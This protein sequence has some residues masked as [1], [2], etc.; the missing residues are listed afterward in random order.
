M[1]DV[2]SLCSLYVIYARSQMLHSHASHP[3]AP[4]TWTCFP[5]TSLLKMLAT[6]WNQQK[7][8]WTVWSDTRVKCWRRQT[9]SRGPQSQKRQTKILLLKERKKH[10]LYRKFPIAECLLKRMHPL[11]LAQDHTCYSDIFHSWGKNKQQTAFLL[12]SLSRV[13]TFIYLEQQSGLK[14]MHQ[15]LL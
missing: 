14:Q 6:K 11:F 12:T 1:V 10:L 5:C 7:A 8:E 9:W 3:D 2:F 4:G 15:A 13:I